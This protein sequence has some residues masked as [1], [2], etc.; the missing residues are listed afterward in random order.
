MGK[1]NT[2]YTRF[3]QVALTRIDSVHFAVV[4][5]EVGVGEMLPEVGAFGCELKDFKRTRV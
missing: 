2:K 1:V 3:Y 5:L 4:H